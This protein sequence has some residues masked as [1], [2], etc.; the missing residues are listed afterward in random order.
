M[1]RRGREHALAALGWD[2]PVALMLERLAALAARVPRRLAPATPAPAG[3]EAFLYRPDWAKAEWV[4]VL[5]SYLLAFKPG[6]PVALV[7]P[8]AGTPGEPGLAEIQTRLLTLAQGAGVAAFAD[9]VLV[10]QPLELAETLAGYGTVTVVPSGRGS[11][12]GLQGPYGLRLA[13]ARTRLCQG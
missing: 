3:P 13:A 2:R 9:V 5:L 7:L 12:E 11:V 8:W 4:E 6:D 1:G 10:D